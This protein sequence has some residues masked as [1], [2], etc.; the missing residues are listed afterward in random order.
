MS[1]MKNKK[2]YISY[3]GGEINAEIVA[4]TEEEAIEKF[5]NGDCEYSVDESLLWPDFAEVEETEEIEEEK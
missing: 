5:L 1:I 3:R 4:G 2:F